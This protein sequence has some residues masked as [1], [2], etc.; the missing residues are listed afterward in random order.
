MYGKG[1]NSFHSLEACNFLATAVTI[2]FI[3]N[4]FKGIEQCMQWKR[5][6]RNEAKFS[7]IC[8]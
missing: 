7:Y 8:M 5:K 4:T 2:L 1:V 3:P 6:S